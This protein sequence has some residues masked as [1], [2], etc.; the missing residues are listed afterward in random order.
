MIDLMNDLEIKKR[1][2]EAHRVTSIDAE[3]LYEII[4]GG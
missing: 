4:Q 3:A 2:K 1:A